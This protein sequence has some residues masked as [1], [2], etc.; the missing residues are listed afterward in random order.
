MAGLP[1][2]FCRARRFLALAFGRFLAGSLSARTSLG[3]S[4]MVGANWAVLTSCPYSRSASVRSFAPPPMYQKLGNGDVCDPACRCRVA[5]SLAA[6]D[7]GKYCGGWIRARQGTGARRSHNIASA[8]HNEKGLLPVE[9]RQV[10]ALVCS[11]AR[12]GS[13][14]FG[15]GGLG[16]RRRTFVYTKFGT[17][18]P[19]EGHGHTQRGLGIGAREGTTAGHC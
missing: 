18:G 6:H 3:K 11:R 4:A 8:W 15:G 7:G 16:E 2:A 9:R 1:V 10:V 13:G 14:G 5:A 12:P 19:G 17:C